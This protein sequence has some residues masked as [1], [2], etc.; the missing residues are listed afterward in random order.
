MIIFGY[1][2][3]VIQSKYHG[4]ND[5]QWMMYNNTEQLWDVATS[6]HNISE[7]SHL[8]HSSVQPNK[9]MRAVSNGDC[10]IRVF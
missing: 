6:Q 3:T 5:T 4:Y 7:L 8:L 10:S 1:H 9:L 2:A